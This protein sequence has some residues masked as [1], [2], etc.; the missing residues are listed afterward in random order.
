MPNSSNQPKLTPKQ[1]RKKFN[2][3]VDMDMYH[4]SKG[5]TKPVLVGV[6]IRNCVNRNIK[7]ETCY[8]FSEFKEAE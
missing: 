1:R 3:W 2:K 5:T 4:K 7:C 6:C 8:R